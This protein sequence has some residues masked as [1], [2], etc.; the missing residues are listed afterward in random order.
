M[1]SGREGGMWL[2]VSLNQTTSYNFRFGALLNVTGEERKHGVEGRGPIVANYLKS[3][4]KA[5]NYVQELQKSAESHNAYNFVAVEL[6]NQS[7]VVYYHS[8][9]PKTCLAFKDKQI[10]SFGNSAAAVPLTKVTNGKDKFEQIVETYGTSQQ[11]DTLVAELVNLL[12]WEQKHLPDPE[13]KRRSPAGFEC[14]SSVYVRVLQAG[15]GTRAHSLVLI[16]YE[17]NVEFTEIA[18]DQPIDGEN[19]TWQT[20]HVK[21]HL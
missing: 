4:I 17:G 14:L 16:D 15:Y 12:K 13:L 1:E 7:S 18:M 8:N 5:E 6:N 10:L 21:A 3:E 20:F 9:K 11:R 19:P 2:G